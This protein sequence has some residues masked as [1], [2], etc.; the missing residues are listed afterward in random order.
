MTRMDWLVTLA[1][2]VVLA[3]LAWHAYRKQHPAVYR[4]RVKRNGEPC[5]R[6]Y[7][8]REG[9]RIHF[10]NAHQLS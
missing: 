10:R 8:N 9:R 2:F 6:A 3:G 5:G 1:P 7:P 4:C